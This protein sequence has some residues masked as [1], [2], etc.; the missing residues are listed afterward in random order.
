M[1]I[2]DSYMSTI[3]EGFNAVTVANAGKYFLF[4]SCP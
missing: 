2:V 3:P 1:M 4:L